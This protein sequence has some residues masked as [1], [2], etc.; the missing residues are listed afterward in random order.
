MAGP[1]RRTSHA[2]E[3]FAVVVIDVYSLLVDLLWIVIVCRYS[4][5]LFVC[6]VD[7]CFLWIEVSLEL[8]WTAVGRIKMRHMRELHP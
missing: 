8:Q 3:L 5:F 7:L 6:S 2:S 1:R 4:L